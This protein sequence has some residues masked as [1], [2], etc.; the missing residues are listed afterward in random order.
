MAYAATCSDRGVRHRVNQDAVCVQVARTRVGEVGMLVVCDGVGGL[1]SGEVAS[2]TVVRRFARWFRSELPE[3]VGTPGLHG[4]AWLDAIE[5]DWRILLDQLNASL[6]VYGKARGCMVGTTVS[7][8]LAGCG[9]FLGAQ[10]G[11]GRVLKLC[12]DS[13]EQVSE[14]QTLLALKLR[15]GELQSEKDALPGDANTILQAIGTERLLRPVFYRGQ[16]SA[17]ELMVVCT[18]GA[19]RKATNEGIGEVFSSRDYCDERGLGRAC[20]RLVKLDI[21]RG[22]TDNI[23]VACLSGNLRQVAG[24]D[25]R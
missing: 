10:V 19:W 24:G 25:E 6:G 17:D 20:R 3:R 1:D 16:I 5:D 4:D 8:V 14:D 12:L 15:R 9:R 21:E 7:A 23:S 13:V 18:D 22:E 2:A 11:D